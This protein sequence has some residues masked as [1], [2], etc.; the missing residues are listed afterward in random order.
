[1]SSGM[2]LSSQQE[3]EI[4]ATYDHESY[5]RTQA[6]IQAGGESYEKRRSVPPPVRQTRRLHRF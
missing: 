2:S 4:G 3:S 5:L 1:M 6:V